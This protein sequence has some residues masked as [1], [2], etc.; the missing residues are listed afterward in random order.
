MIMYLGANFRTLLVQEKVAWEQSQRIIEPG[1]ELSVPQS[2]VPLNLCFLK[3]VIVMFR[4]ILRLVSWR[5]SQ[6]GKI[7][8]ENSWD[9]LQRIKVILSF[10]RNFANDGNLFY[11]I[12]NKTFFWRLHG[13]FLRSISDQTY[14]S[15]A[16]APMSVYVFDILE[17]AEIY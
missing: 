6:L 12:G 9:W 11:Y 10:S 14:S 1:L 3:R 4:G 13:L 16:S 17:M 8:F 7:W 2:S 5:S 15:K